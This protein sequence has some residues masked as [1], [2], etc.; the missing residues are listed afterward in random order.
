[1]QALQAQIA[2]YV[3]RVRRAP[4][5]NRRLIELQRNYGLY[6][7]QHDT[8]LAQREAYR[9]KLKLEEAARKAGTPK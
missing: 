5:G 2:D 8:M 7:A 1:M 3:A 6:K 9:L 4:Q